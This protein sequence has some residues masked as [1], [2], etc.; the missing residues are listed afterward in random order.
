MYKLDDGTVKPLPI[1]YK[2]LLRLLKIFVDYCQ[3]IGL[4]IK[5]WTAVTKKDFDDFRTS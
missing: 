3:D 5:D 2:N 1:S 4:P